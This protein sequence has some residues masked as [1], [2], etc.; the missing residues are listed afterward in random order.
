MK[1]LCCLVAYLALLVSHTSSAEMENGGFILFTTENGF[2]QILIAD[3]NDGDGKYDA[4]E[5][6][7]W[8]S[9]GGKNDA[10]IDNDSFD[11]ALRE[12]EE[13]TRCNYTRGDIKAGLISGV[14]Y[15]QQLD[16]N[17]SWATYFSKVGGR[18]SGIFKKYPTGNSC[19]GEK[20]ATRERSEYRWVSW[21][22]LVK[23][24][25]ASGG[26]GSRVYLKHSLP[27]E[28][29]NP[30]LRYEFAKSLFEMRKAQLKGRF[31]LPFVD[32]KTPDNT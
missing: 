12:S 30:Y 14:K 28:T 1:F 18:G 27:N 3:S 26:D 5:A 29:N 2:I 6:R 13:E 4:K 22:N 20:R 7:I 15:R 32:S 31:K 25:D 24:L 19:F 11:T 21:S 16:G 23:D 9:F 17:K 10:D 8:S